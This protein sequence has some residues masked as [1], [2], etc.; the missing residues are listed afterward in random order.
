MLSRIFKLRWLGDETN[1]EKHKKE[2]KMTHHLLSSV[3]K[4]LLKQCLNPRSYLCRF[5]WSRQRRAGQALIGVLA[6]MA[7]VSLLVS[8]LVLNSLISADGALR[9]RQSG[10]IVN[11][12]EAALQ[13]AVIQLERDPNYPG[14]TLNFSEGQVIIEISG[15]NP[16][17]ILAKSQTSDGKILRQLQAEVSFE[18]NGV[19]TVD[20]WQELY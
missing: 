20:N 9:L 19:A 15:D 4:K 5:V 16:K 3:Y 13:N 14:E 17:I 1:T 2:H 7:I 10:N 8:S 11:L 18:S 12:A 6:I